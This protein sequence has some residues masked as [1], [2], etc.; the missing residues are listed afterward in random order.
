M[1]MQPKKALDSWLFV[2]I[3]GGVA[4]GTAF[5]HMGFGALIGVALGG[6]IEASSAKPPR[7]I[8][9]LFG[10]CPTR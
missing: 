9:K 1:N 4:L 8:A 6:A 10:G 7:A 3:I 5:G 2:G